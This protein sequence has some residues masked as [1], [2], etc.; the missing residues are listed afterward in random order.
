VRKPSNDSLP[1]NGSLPADLLAAQRLL[2]QE[3]NALVGELPPNTLA[4]NKARPMPTA[5]IRSGKYSIN[6]SK[7]STRWVA[8][9]RSTGLDSQARSC[10]STASRS[11]PDFEA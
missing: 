6:R 5:R 8:K 3:I 2:R 4:S 9:C 1:S 7:Y 11:N 10:L